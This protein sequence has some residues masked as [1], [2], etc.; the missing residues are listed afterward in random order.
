V[1]DETIVHDVQDELPEAASVRGEYRIELKLKD[2]TLTFDSQVRFRS[3]LQSFHYS[4]RRRLLKD[5][6]L[7]REKTWEDT[8]PRDHQ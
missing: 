1:F 3:D 6:V 4:N 8:I 5:G 7:V 2:R